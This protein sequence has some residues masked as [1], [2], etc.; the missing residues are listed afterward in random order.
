MNP[1]KI[2][3]VHESIFAPNGREADELREA[4]KEKRTFLLN[5]RS[6]PGAGKTTLLINLI[7]RRKKDY[8]IGVREADIDSDVDAVSIG[9]KTGVESIQVHTGGRCHLDA[10]RTQEARDA[11]GDKHFDF[12]IL[13]NVGNLVCPAEF[14]TGACLN[15]ALL[16]L[17]EGDDKPEKYPL[18]FE[19]ADRVVLTKIDTREYFDFDIENAKKWIKRR[20]RDS[21]ILEVSAKTDEGRD[22]LV[23]FRKDKIERWNK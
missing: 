3:D 22:E 4:L 9:E 13:E 6:S 14:D 17:P 12:L 23:K 18:R 1:P 16:S 11:L 10:S 7:N 5:V 15:R 20:N 2:I 21:I 19:K 8:R